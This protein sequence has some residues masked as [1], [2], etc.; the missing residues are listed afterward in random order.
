VA[1]AN[2]PE[3]RRSDSGDRP[4]GSLRGILALQSRSPRR[5]GFSRLRRRKGCS[6][7]FL[8]ANIICCEH[9]KG[10]GFPLCWL[11]WNIRPPDDLCVATEISA[12]AE[13][14]PCKE[15]PE[16]IDGLRCRATA[17]HSEDLVTACGSGA[18][19][20]LEPSWCLLGW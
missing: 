14:G 9:L 10:C 13:Y 2:G 5:K 6:G 4:G 20:P 8:V 16:G 1:L 3:P 11:P 15:A 12:A 17:P 7:S 18:E 19:G